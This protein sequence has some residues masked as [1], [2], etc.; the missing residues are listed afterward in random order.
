ME[1]TSLEC[2]AVLN[3][4]EKISLLLTPSSLVSHNKNILILMVMGVQ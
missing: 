1:F 2:I 4:V 3:F